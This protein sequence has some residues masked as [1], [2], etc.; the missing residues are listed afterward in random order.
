[1]KRIAL[2]CL[3]L[4]LGLILRGQGR[5]IE[6]FA[7]GSNDKQWALLNIDP[8]NAII[9]L[10]SAEVH[11]TRNGVLQAFLPLGKH[12]FV[13]ES[14]YY[15]SYESQ[16]ELTDSCKVQLDIHLVPAFGYARVS[17]PLRGGMIFIDGEFCG[18]EKTPPCKLSEGSHRVRLIRDTLKFYDGVFQLESGG[19]NYL[20]IT[21]Y[22]ITPASRSEMTAS[23]LA[24]AGLAGTAIEDEIIDENSTTWGMLNLHSNVAGATVLVNGVEYGL[25]PCIIKGLKP[26]V[27]YRF[28]VRM[29]GWRE[30]TRMVYVKSGEMQEIEITLKKR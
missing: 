9:T 27:R 23:R 5:A 10:D 2:V 14:P 20:E 18:K 13:I 17:T 22:T 16:F 29:D 7:S 19:K 24:Q 25:T 12:A 15:H 3:L 4:S 1:M 6:Q 8:P 21:E 11:T 28:T 26:S 30:Q